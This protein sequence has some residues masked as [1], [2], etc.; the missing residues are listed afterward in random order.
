MYCL[1]TARAALV[2]AA[3]SGV[4]LDWE[5]NVRFSRRDP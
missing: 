5:W 4:L 2:L 3:L 1:A